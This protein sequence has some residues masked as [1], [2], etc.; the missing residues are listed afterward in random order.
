MGVKYASFKYHVGDVIDTYDRHLIII[1]MEYRSVAK[2]KNG[3]EYTLNE[4]WYK[5]KC[6]DCG[7]EDWIYEYCLGDNMHIGCNACCVP[8]KKVV[9]GVNDV[10][11][12]AAWMVKYFVDKHDVYLNTK[13]SKEIV[14]M[15]CPDCGRI[16]RKK[17]YLVA[18]NR[19]L[20]CPCSDGWSYPNKFMYAMLEQLNVH[21]EPEKH[22]LWS[23]NR[24]YDDYIEYNGLKI[25][26]EQHGKQHY[27]RPFGNTDR[28]RSLDQ[29]IQNDKYKYNL[30]MS[31]GIDYYFVIDSSVSTQEYMQTSIIN[32]GLLHVL[33]VS[34]TDIDWIKCDEFAVRNFAKL[35]CTYKKDHPKTTLHQ[36]ADLFNISYNTVLGY[37]KSG[38]KFGWCDYEFDDLQLTYRE[39]MRVVNQRP[40]YCATNNTYYRNSNIAAQHLTSD[41]I[42]FYPRQIRTS[43]KRNGEYRRFKFH[44]VSQKE[45]N[46]KKNKSP[47]NVIGDLFVLGEDYD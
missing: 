30:A 39:N 15:V 46:I 1:D 20:S 31:N 17:I 24:V 40:I 18:S 43:I 16:H 2:S 38:N 42:I 3:K 35:I 9:K 8:P 33:G 21:F 23:E 14:N 47:N 27:S 7:N 29:E 4:K 41:K 44:Y 45:F 22:F 36:I 34:E 6:L 25:I 26:T 28:H 32:S 37:I 13:Y 19:G 10:S 5:Y 11:T 12:T